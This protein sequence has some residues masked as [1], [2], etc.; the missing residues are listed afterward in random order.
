MNGPTATNTNFTLTRTGSTSSSAWQITQISGPDVSS[1]ASYSKPG[2]ITKDSRRSQG[3]FLTGQTNATL[4]ANWPVPVVWK[5]GLKSK[6]ERRTFSDER[7]LDRYTFVGPNYGPYPSEF[8]WDLGETEVNVT[9]ISGG[10]IFMPDL[11]DLGELFRTNPELF[12]NSSTPTDYYNTHVVRNRNFTERIDAAYLMGTAQVKGFTLRAGLRYEDTTTKVLEPDARSSAEVVAAGYAVNTSGV[13]TTIPGID[14]QFLSR[15]RITRRGEYD[16]LFPSASLRYE[17]IKDLEWHVGFSSTIRRPSYSNV[18]GVWVVNDNNQR[19]SAPNI[20]LNPETAT[21]F[22]ARLAYYLKNVGEFSVAL[23]ENN[24]SDLINTSELTAQEFGYTGE[25][26]ADYRFITS[27]NTPGRVKVRSL[28]L[29]Y[30][31]NLG[32]LGNAFRRLNLRANY[33]RAYASELKTGLVPH[34]LNSG[35]SYTYRRFHVYANGNWNDDYP[36]TTTGAT[37]HRHRIQVDAGASYKITPKLSLSVS[38]RNLTDSP[39]I[40]MQEVAPSGPTLY[41]HLRTGTVY[42]LAMKGTF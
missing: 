9:S 27:A 12:V 29:S 4:T 3:K 6:E 30:N 24:V 20:G 18:A 39:Y 23:Y 26:Y 21:N 34:S 8:A 33:T 22:A 31:Q 36:L 38:A 32:F 42:T 37:Y 11:A 7:A 41:D 19:V 14:Y 16:N 17:I 10:R 1:G 2:I 25:E 28:E 40:Q 13:A 5:T 35:V 15:P